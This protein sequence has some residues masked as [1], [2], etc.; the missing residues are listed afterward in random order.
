MGSGTGMASATSANPVTE[1][2]WCQRRLLTHKQAQGNQ[3]MWHWMKFLAQENCDFGVQEGCDSE[4]L[5]TG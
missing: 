4:R 3:Q 2:A 1:Q 5:S